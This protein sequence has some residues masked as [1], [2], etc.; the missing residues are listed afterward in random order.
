MNGPNYDR[1]CFF[2]TETIS[3]NPNYI[4]SLAYIYYEN[5]KK[6]S[7]N[8]IVMNP[9]YPISPQASAVNGFTD[10]MVKDK[11][12]FDDV[13]PTIKQ[14]FTNSIWVCHNLPFDKRALYTEFR[15]YDIEI[16][17]F[18]TCDTLENAKNYIAKGITENYKLGTLCDYFGI[19][20]KNWHTADADT[21]AC[22]RVFNKLINLSN[23][24]LIIRTRYNQI[25]KEE[26]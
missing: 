15:R 25:Y 14:Y 19:E 12:K 10:D 2:D 9:D 23:G 11:P 26:E 17:D 20:L 6:V 4:I 3:I 7:Q 1:I 16:P 22:M 18:F 8:C 21:L 5:G 13:W 24:D